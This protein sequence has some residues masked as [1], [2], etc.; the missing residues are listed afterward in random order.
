MVALVERE[1]NTRV[2]F[3]YDYGTGFEVVAE[4]L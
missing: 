1:D 2:L 3:R 4:N